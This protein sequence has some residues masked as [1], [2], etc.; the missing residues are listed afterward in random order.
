[1]DDPNSIVELIPQL[2]WA[3]IKA[4]RH[5]YSMVCIKEDLNPKEGQPLHT[6]EATLHAYTF[7]LKHELSIN[8]KGIPTQWLPI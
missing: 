3:I 6:V 8:M 2:V 1:M 7:L 5:Y 4:T